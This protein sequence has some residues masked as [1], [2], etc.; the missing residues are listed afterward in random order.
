MDTLFFWISKLIWRCLS[1]DSMLLILLIVSWCLLWRGRL[2]G[3]RRLLGVTVAVLILVT[4]FPV[5]EWLIYPLERQCPAHPALP[6]RVDGIIVLGGAENAV[7]SALWQQI[8]LGDSAERLTAFMVLARQ[9]PRARLVFT[10]G[11]GSLTTPEYRGADALQGFFQAQGLD[12]SRLLFERDS[13]NTYENV[14]Y[15]QRLVQPDPNETWVVVTSA[16]HMPRTLGIFDQAGWRVIPYPVDHWSSPGRLL[17]IDPNLAGHLRNLT[18]AAKEW[19]GLL[20]YYVTGKTSTL[21]PGP[22]APGKN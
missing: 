19:T 7:R 14:K 21:L 4:L 15:S 5:D 17:R 18:Y 8:E 12:S 9:Y 1:P 13:R 20:A 16:W 11:S 6:A 2:K 3:A 22:P 10:G